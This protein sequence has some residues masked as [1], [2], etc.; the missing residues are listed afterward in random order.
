LPFFTD[1]LRRGRI[2]GDKLSS[3]R[4]KTCYGLAGVQRA[5]AESPG[6]SDY[7]RCDQQSLHRQS[8][9][10]CDCSRVIGLH[11]QF[12][13]ELVWSVDCTGIEN[14]FRLARVLFDQVQSELVILK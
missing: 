4:L 1:D 11:H 5:D 3:D 6:D 13:Q 7:E 14:K 12:A 2:V 10:L 8:S 9:F